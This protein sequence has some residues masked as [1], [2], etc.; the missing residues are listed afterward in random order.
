MKQSNNNIVLYLIITFIV[1]LGILV[2]FIPQSFW[3]KLSMTLF[4]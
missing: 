1:I 4:K 2:I 3:V